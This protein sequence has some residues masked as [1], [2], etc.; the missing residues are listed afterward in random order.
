MAMDGIF[1][2]NFRKM[3]AI[4][5][6]VHGCVNVRIRNAFFAAKLKLFR[7]ALTKTSY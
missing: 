3:D 7:P 1:S 4:P 5:S 6:A 2:D